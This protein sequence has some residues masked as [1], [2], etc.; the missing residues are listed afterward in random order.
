MTWLNLWFYSTVLH[1][2][3]ISSLLWLVGNSVK[4][5]FLLIASKYPFTFLK[6]RYKKSTHFYIFEI[7]EGHISNVVSKNIFLRLFIY[8]NFIWNKIFYIDNISEKVV[9]RAFYV[10]I[11]DFISHFWFISLINNFFQPVICDVKW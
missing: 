4:Y 2:F 3:F 5:S 8:F 10:Y 7:F 9:C 6:I 1:T 11:F